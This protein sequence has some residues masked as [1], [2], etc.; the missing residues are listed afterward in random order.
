MSENNG[1]DPERYRPL[2]LLQ[3]RQMCLD[4]QLRRRFDPSDLV[5]DTLVL[6]HNKKSQCHAQT[7]GGRVCWLL[8]ILRNV[9]RDRIRFEMAD[10]RNPEREQSLAA[11]DES[12]AHFQSVIADRGEPP[13]REAER[14]EMQLR[15]AEA[16]QQLPEDECDAV[17]CHYLWD[18]PVAEIAQRIGRTQ[19]AVAALWWRGCERL[20][21]LLKDYQPGGD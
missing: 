9:V 17:V 19:K 13:D 11:V 15:L 21:K 1:W 7:E 20:K 3:A 5:Q 2:L 8:Q 18:R 10:I 12:S 14:H 16:L 6:A 4:K